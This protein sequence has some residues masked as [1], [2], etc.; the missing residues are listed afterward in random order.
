VSTASDPPGARAVLREALAIA[1][2]LAREGKLTAAQQGWPQALRDM[3]NIDANDPFRTSTSTNRRPVVIDG[4][5][6][7][8][9]ARKSD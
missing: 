2:T 9:S 7:G 8:T 6:R 1:E 5:L 4:I 3:L